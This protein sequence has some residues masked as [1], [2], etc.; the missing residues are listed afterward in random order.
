MIKTNHFLKNTQM[1]FKEQKKLVLDILKQGDRQEIAR[2]AGVTPTTVL[3]SL[4]LES[5][6]G[7]TDKQMRVWE[8]AIDFVKERQQ[9]A[10]KIESKVVALAEKLA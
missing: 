5:L 10:A 2:R 7:A 8:E 9:R 3:T 1:D 4:G 6:D